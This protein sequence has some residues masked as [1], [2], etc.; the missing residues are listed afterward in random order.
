MSKKEQIRRLLCDFPG[1]K[2]SGNDFF[3]DAII[4]NKPFTLSEIFEIE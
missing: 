2:Q 1:M 4:S 3:V